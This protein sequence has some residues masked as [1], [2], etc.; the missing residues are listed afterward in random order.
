MQPY[1]QHTR[2]YTCIYYA[3]IM[4]YTLIFSTYATWFTLDLIHSYIL[5]TRLVD[6][7]W[8]YYIHSALYTHMFYVHVWYMHILCVYNVLNTYIFYIH[9][10]L[11]AWSYTPMW[12]MYTCD[13][14]IHNVLYTYIFYIH[15]AIYTWSNTLIFILAT[16]PEGK[17]TTN[18]NPYN[19]GTSGWW[20]ARFFWRELRC[21][22]LVCAWVY[23]AYGVGRCF[24]LTESADT[25]YG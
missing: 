24:L 1:F 17:W 3:Y 21:L 18:P 19:A 22:L 4:P 5:Y 7:I 10:A 11:Y 14:C 2:R 25:L 15:N 16:H 12:S 8:M 9:N 13:T 20:E 6:S 23:I